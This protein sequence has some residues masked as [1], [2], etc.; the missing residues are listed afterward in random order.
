MRKADQTGKK[1]QTKRTGANT[2]AVV[3]RASASLRQKPKAAIAHP[4]GVITLNA[5]DSREFVKM[6]N[7]PA[8]EP[9][10][11][12]KAALADYRRLIQA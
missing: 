8:R 6:L 11:Y 1:A 5:A 12:M 7:A 4:D 9:N 10:E 3:R 2:R